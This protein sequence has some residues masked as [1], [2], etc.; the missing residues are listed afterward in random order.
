MRKTFIQSLLNL[1]DQDDRV[2][3]LTGD[4]GFHVLEPF[5]E[6]HPDRFINVGV[7]EQNMVGIATG[8]AEAGFIPFVYSIATFATLR[9]YEFIRNGPVQH[10]LPVRIVGV[11]SGFEYGHGGLSHHAL[12]DVGALRLFPGLSIIAPVDAPQA[13]SALQA[14][15]DLPG[16]I[17]YRLG[18]ND[19]QI[20]DELDGRYTHGRTQTIL[21]GTDVLLLASGAVA[22]EAVTAAHRLAASGIHAHVEA[23]ACVAPIPRESLIELTARFSVVVTVEAHMQTGGIGSLVSEIVAEVGI[24]CRVVRLGV[25]ELENHLLGDN[26]YMLRK[27]KLDAD[28]I[29][30]TV[31]SLHK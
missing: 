24:Q 3:L 30:Q 2:F 28:G 26:D 10:H 16:P 31:L 7:A 17:Y 29:V 9:P 1:A 25:K 4:L 20:I 23:I 12:E 13:S 27:H 6:S 18:K 22:E 21:E 11:G 8:L 19:N 14:T 5:I 15:W